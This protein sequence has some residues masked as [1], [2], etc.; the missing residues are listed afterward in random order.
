MKMKNDAKL[1]KECTCQFKTDMKNWW[2]FTQALKNL[3]NLH[4]NRLFLTK[5]YNVWAKKV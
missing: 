2:I 3:K 1:E 4:F 5:V